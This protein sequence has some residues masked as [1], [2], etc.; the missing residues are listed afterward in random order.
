MLETCDIVLLK[1]GNQPA[2]PLRWLP[3]GKVFCRIDLG[4]GC[5][6]IEVWRAIFP[7]DIVGAPKSLTDLL[8]PCP[9]KIEMREV[10]SLDDLGVI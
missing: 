7:R 3:N 4:Y 5:Q 2:V 9:A 1:D 6:H 8:G 10:N